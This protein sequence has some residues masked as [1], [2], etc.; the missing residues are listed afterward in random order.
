MIRIAIVVA[1]AVL[2][3]AGAAAAQEPPTPGMIT[4][5]IWT[6]L[7]APVDL[8]RLYPKAAKGAAGS[9]VAEGLV[10]GSGRFADCAIVREEPAGLGFGAATLEL[11]KLFRQRSTDADG[12][13][14]EG[15]KLRLPVRWA[16]PR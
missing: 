4:H 9:V 15:R 14:T 2:A 11:C 13:P 12:L 8:A 6:K 1:T 16:P 10:D 7:P 3:L 5:P